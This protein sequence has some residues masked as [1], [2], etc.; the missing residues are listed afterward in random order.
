[1]LTHELPTMNYEAMSARL[2]CT[3]E[4][5]LLNEGAMQK[6]MLM[7]LL[8]PMMNDDVM[9]KRSYVTL[10]LLREMMMMHMRLP[11]THVLLMLNDVL[12]KRRR[13]HLMLYVML[14]RYDELLLMF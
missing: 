1:M 5:P 4:L 12:P 2:L 8:L 11:R 13:Q 6:R 3:R 10:L 14:Q 9:Q 7:T